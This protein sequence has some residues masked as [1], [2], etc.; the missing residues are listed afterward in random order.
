MAEW[1]PLDI[2][3]TQPHKD[4]H[5]HLCVAKTLG[6]LHTNLNDY[7]KLVNDPKFICKEC[8]RVANEEQHLCYPAPL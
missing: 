6:Y 8:G 4:H 1:F 7:K 2:E 3:L 5:R